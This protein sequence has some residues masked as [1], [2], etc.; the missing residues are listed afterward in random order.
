MRDCINI[1]HTFFSKS[2]LN[3]SDE[4]EKAYQICYTVI[5]KHSER[6]TST[7]VFEFWCPK[8]VWNNNKNYYTKDGNQFFKK[9]K[10]IKVYQVDRII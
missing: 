4:T 10:F 6:V 9:P 3:I 7:N 5:F 2:K 8:S 1:A